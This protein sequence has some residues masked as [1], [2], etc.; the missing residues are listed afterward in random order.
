MIVVIAALFS[1]LL[2]AYLSCFGE[3]DSTFIVQFDYGLEI[4]HLLDIIRNF[5]MEYTD[6][7]EPRKPIRNCGRIMVRYATSTLIFDLIAQSAWPL[8]SAVRDTWKPD[9]A[10]LLYLLRL[11]R[12]SKVMILMDL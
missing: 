2:A 9:D 5:M 12:L 11:L 8:H 6:P 3:P 1:S 7:H 10:N 4:V